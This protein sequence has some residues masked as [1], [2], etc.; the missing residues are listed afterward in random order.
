[1]AG[2]APGEAQGYTISRLISPCCGMEICLI[3]RQFKQVAIK[4][5]PHQLAGQARNFRVSR[6]ELTWERLGDL[7]HIGYYVPTSGP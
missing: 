4:N 7:V 2:R 5:L 1:M 3:I 6:Q